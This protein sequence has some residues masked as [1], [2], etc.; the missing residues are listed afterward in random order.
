[1]IAVKTLDM[2][3]RD[4]F[5]KLRILWLSSSLQTATDI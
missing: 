2:P 4:F 1:M 5:S 3:K